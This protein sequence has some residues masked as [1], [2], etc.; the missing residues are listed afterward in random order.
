MPHYIFE[1]RGCGVHV[2][3]FNRIAD[4]DTPPEDPCA[5]DT[6][7]WRRTIQ[8]PRVMNNS[9]LDGSGRFNTLRETM[10]LKKERAYAR[11]TG[12]RTSEKKIDS[13]IKVVNK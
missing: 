1:C 5:C 2:E 6:P 13:E 8:A 12:D 9:K 11:E 3:T 10:K 7:N 4:M